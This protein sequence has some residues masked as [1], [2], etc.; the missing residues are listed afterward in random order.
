MTVND[1]DGT[2]KTATDDRKERMDLVN[3]TMESTLLH[4]CNTN[5]MILKVLDSTLT[6]MMTPFSSR[7]NAHNKVKSRE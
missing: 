2:G 1:D 3:M 5:R 4:S 7:T 6:V